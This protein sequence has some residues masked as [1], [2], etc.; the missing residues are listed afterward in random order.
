MGLECCRSEPLLVFLM[1]SYWPCFD[2]YVWFL[3]ICES[4]HPNRSRHTAAHIKPGSVVIR[5]RSLF[6]V[7]R[8]KSENA[9]NIMLTMKT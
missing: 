1:C 3:F 5:I 6:V 8:N 9:L 4:T 7:R 2:S